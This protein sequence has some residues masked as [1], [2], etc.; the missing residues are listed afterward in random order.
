MDYRERLMLSS[1]KKM[2][3]LEHQKI[4]KNKNIIKNL[5]VGTLIARKRQKKI[6]FS[7]KIGSSEMGLTKDSNRREK[8]IYGHYLEC[9]M[10]NTKMI[11]SI[12]EET[13]EL[14]ENCPQKEVHPLLI[15]SN[16]VRE[17]YSP[18]DW[19][20]MNE[21][22]ETNTLHVER[23]QYR[24]ILGTIVRS[25]SEANIANTFERLGIPYRYEQKL[26]ISGRMVF[27]DYI[28]RLPNGDMVLWEH[29]GLIEDDAYAERANEKIKLYEA[30]GYRQH[31]NLIITYEDDIRTPQQIESIIKRFIIF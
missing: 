7:E 23:L 29:N 25:K 2:L 31:T 5:K 3:R 17:Q 27:P 26:Y 20:W 9:D 13:I 16:E 1:I 28:I 22:Y 18:D 11:A 8:V 15:K 19:K 14:I 12:L 10:H 4:E 6:Y 21:S 30:A 24:T